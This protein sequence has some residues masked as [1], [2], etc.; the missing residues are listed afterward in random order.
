MCWNTSCPAS[1]AST[2]STSSRTRPGPSSSHAARPRRSSA[3]RPRT[4]CAARAD[5]RIGAVLGRSAAT[6]DR[7]ASRS[8]GHPDRLGRGGG[9]AYRQDTFGYAP[10]DAFVLCADGLA[11]ARDRTG[12]HFSVTERDI[13]R[14]TAGD[15]QVLLQQFQD[16]LLRRTRGRPNDDVALVAV[17]SAAAR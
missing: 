12:A 6:G 10:G 15:P 5:R 4:P 11:E 13:A 17:Q 9:P 14:G 7:G 8:E 2:S 1:A 16:D 3:T